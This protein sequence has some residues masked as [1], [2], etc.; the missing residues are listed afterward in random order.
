MEIQFSNV[1]SAQS[2]RL[3][4]ELELELIRAGV[5]SRALSIKRSSSE[6]MD[7]GSV[8][9]TAV[10]TAVHALAAT[11]YIA[12]FAKCIFEVVKRNETPGIVISTKRGTVTLPLSDISVD[13]LKK[14]LERDLGT[15][16]TRTR[17]QPKQ[18]LKTAKA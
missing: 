4:E 2:G 1:T 10:D 11:G 18:K 16:K 17:R 14:T 13:L 3:A 9:W 8:L 6:T 12:C 5:P 15:K 7:P